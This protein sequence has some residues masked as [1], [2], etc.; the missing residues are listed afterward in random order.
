MPKDPTPESVTDDDLFGAITVRLDGREGEV[1]VEGASVPRVVLR[2]TTGTDRA[3][4]VPIGTRDGAVLTLTVD[5]APAELDLARGRVTRRSYRVDVR[6]AGRSWRLV[7]GSIP[8]SRLLRGRERLGDFSSGGDGRVFAEW[9]RDAA[10]DAT[11][12]A[13][14]YALAAAFGTGGQPMWMMALE[15]A[16]DLLPG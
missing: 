12:A 3:D 14:G 4:H 1:V 13:V 2:R 10:P 5:G 6:Y 7:P 11:D 15:L 9:R 8:S 16:G